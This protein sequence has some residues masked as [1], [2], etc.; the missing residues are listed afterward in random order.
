MSGY[1][2]IYQPVYTEVSGCTYNK[3]VALSLSYVSVM[4]MSAMQ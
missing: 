1:A 4:N 2:H 3:L